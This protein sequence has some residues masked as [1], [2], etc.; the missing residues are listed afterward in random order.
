MSD[1][2][3]MMQCLCVLH[4]LYEQMLSNRLGKLLPRLLPSFT[5]PSLGEEVGCTKVLRYISFSPLGYPQQEM[6]LSSVR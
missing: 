1:G 4:A 6:A 5:D 2:N 3:V